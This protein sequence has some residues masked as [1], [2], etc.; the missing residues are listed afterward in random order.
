[1]PTWGRKAR[2]P[3][4]VSF[5]RLGLAAR[6]AR[7]A[8]SF[9]AGSDPVHEYLVDQANLRGYLGAYSNRTE[10]GALDPELSE[11]AIV[12]GLL[13]P[14]APAETRML[15][16]VVR[17]L[18]RGDFDPDRLVL[19]AKRERAL[20][21]LAMLVGWIPDAELTP[22]IAALREAIHRRPPRSP[23]PPPLRYDARRLLRRRAQ[24]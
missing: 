23:R 14:H 9:P 17:I 6:A 1:M 19:W 15:K 12:V 8:S 11:E 16:L 22:S 21:L 2:Q 13:Q 5:F 7:R 10:W 24:P 3:L 18:Q 20:D 4:H